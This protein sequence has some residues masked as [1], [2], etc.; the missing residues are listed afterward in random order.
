[1]IDG[2]FGNFKCRIFLVVCGCVWVCGG[3]GGDGLDN[4]ASIFGGADLI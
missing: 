2:F 3:G 4:L 1:M